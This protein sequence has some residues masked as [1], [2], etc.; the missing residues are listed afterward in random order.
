MEKQRRIYVG[1]ISPS[2]HYALWSVANFGEIVPGIATYF[3]PLCG[4]DLKGGDSGNEP[5][6]DFLQ[7]ICPRTTGT[8]QRLQWIQLSPNVTFEATKCT[9]FSC[10]SH[11]NL[12]ACNC[13]F[14]KSLQ[15]TD[16]AQL[17]SNRSTQLKS[18]PLPALT[19]CLQIV[20]I[21]NR[22]SRKFHPQTPR[23]TLTTELSIFLEFEVIEGAI[24]IKKTVVR[25][26]GRGFGGF[27]AT[28][29]GRQYPKN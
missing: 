3:S 13:L 1:L 2:S 29:Y 12:C 8:M 11:Y 20:I 19:C 15:T 4:N 6:G 16:H 18:G 10:Y 23:L 9:L 27:E 25:E 28:Q 7:T 21:Q 5:L 26:I 17:I 24:S 22:A 14:F